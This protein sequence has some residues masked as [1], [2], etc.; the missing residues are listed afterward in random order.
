VIQTFLCGKPRKCAGC[1]GWTKVGDQMW[2]DTERQEAHCQKCHDRIEY[3]RR[4][5]ERRRGWASD[6]G[7]SSL[8]NDSMRPFTMGD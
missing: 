7:G 1:D 3:A 4:L 2:H 5:N 6:N 8:D